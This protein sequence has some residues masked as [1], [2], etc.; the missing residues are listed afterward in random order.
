MKLVTKIVCIVALAAALASIT[1]TQIARKEVEEQGQEDLVQKSQAILDQLEGIRDYVADQ[2]GLQ[3][4]INQIV[5][6]YPDGN[7]PQ[8]IKTSILKRV[9]IFASMKVGQDQSERAGYKFRVFAKEPRRKGNLATADETQIFDKFERDPNLKEFVATTDSHIVVYRPVRLS[10]KQGCLLCHGEPSQ[11][12]FK[13]GKDILGHTMENWADGRLHGVFSIKSDMAPTHEAAKASVENILLFALGGLIFSVILAWFILRK[14]L[15]KLRDAVDSIKNSSA[16]LASTS[17]EISSASQNLSSSSTQAAAALEE[18]S[19][20]L[21]ELTSMVKLNTENANSAKDISVSA[22]NSAKVGEEQ[23]RTLIESMKEVSTSSKKVAEIT[24]VID[25]IAFQTNL[26]ALNA[27]VEAA[28]AGEHGKGFAVVADAVRS[29]A[30]KSAVSAKEISDLI[31]QSSTLISS[32]Y[33]YAVKS[34]ETLQAIVKEAEK[35]SVLNNEIAHASVEQTTGIEQISKAVHELDKVTQN[36]AASSE[37]A[38][39]ASVEL[40]RQSE[41]LDDLVGGV[42]DVING[43]KKV[44]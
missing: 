37:E 16:R 1:S 3:E 36:N 26:L 38:A 15:A 17:H 14:P 25:D 42:G 8:D 35:V 9:P 19:A 4:Y 24:T 12:P 2:G 32:S 30:Q 29:L 6:R 18:T 43:A 33:N 34:G 23:I 40:S 28:R 39:A 10:E 7:I 21:E 44:S 22:M 27:S 41:Q 31:S 20:S 13:N 5:A 11:S